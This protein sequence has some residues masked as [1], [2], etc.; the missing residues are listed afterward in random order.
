MS[1]WDAARLGGRT[2][3]RHALGLWDPRHRLAS[4]AYMPPLSQRR[5]LWGK[6][7]FM[8]VFNFA[9]STAIANQI[10][11]RVTITTPFWWTD[12]KLS[13]PGAAASQPQAAGTLQISDVKTGL[14]FMNFGE[15]DQN[16][17][18]VAFTGGA[19][20]PISG[21]QQCNLPYYERRIVEL[22]AGSILQARIQFAAPNTVTDNEQLV[23]G[24]YIE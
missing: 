21:T 16:F 24:G 2:G 12:T 1:V 15:I 4:L 6:R 5:V 22:A 17:A 18:G 3:Q 19:S 11:A 13:V 8:Y 20:L 14:P 23:L 7:R 9:P 10:T